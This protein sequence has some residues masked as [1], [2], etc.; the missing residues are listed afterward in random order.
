MERRFYHLYLILAVL[1]WGLAFV[2][3][4]EVL[5]ELS[6]VSVTL[7]RFIIASLAFMPFSLLL[8]APLLSRTEW[9]LIFAAGICAV[10]GYL[11][12]GA[13]TALVTA[14]T[15]SIIA[16]TSPIFAAPIAFLFLHERMTLWKIL[17]IVGALAGV[18]I[19]TVYGAG[20]AVGVGRVKGIFYLALFS[21]SWAL[22]TIILRPLVARHRA[23]FPLAYS[24]MLGTIAALPLV[25]PQ[26]FRELG[27]MSRD[28]WYQLLYLAVV[29]TFLG[30]S[31]YAKAVQGFGAMISVFY[32]YLVPPVAVFWAWIILEEKPNAAVFGGMALIL[33]SLLAIEWRWQ[34]GY[35]GSGSRYLR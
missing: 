29:S 31:L 1:I 13:G 21:L 15:A 10:Y 14:G 24:I 20:Q 33:V 4:K 17:G 23:F 32:S 7:A 16:D 12:L 27:G 26:F 35:S 11:A 30:Y 3:V 28:G 9:V 34:R 8:R 22:Y 18:A 25:R 6:P 19:I 5:S 2:V